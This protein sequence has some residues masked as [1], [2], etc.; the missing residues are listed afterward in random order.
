V[1]IFLVF[2]LLLAFPSAPTLAAQIEPD[3]PELTESAKL[4][5]RGSV[6]LETGVALS[7]ERRA[8]EPTEKTLE[9]EADIRIGVTRQLEVD[10]EG[11]PFVRV[12]G[13]QDDTGFGDITIGFRYRFIEA[14]EGY[15]W[16]PH[17]AV[18]AFAKL[19]I[20]DEPIGTGRPDFGL[21]LL[22]SFELPWD[23]ELEVNLGA[24]AVGQSSGYLAQALGSASLSHDLT[25]SLFG[26]FEVL[27][28][29]RN[30]R[31]GRGS[32]S[33][34]TGLVYRVTSRLA[35]DTGIQ[36]SLLGEAPDYVVRAG[37]SVRFGR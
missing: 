14:F 4:V 8:G 30:Q 28:A 25:S 29:S 17:L 7:K 31:D 20:A 9:L 35:V 6:Q 2:L 34:N 19:P 23:F 37:L 22:A 1:L 32:M 15:P 3:R 13:P 24:A 18:K 36:T 10:L 11:E 21:L 27:L 26:F 16:P 33:I 5:P 12:R